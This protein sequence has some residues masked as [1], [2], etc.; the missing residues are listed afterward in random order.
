[1]KAEKL[2]DRLFSEIA[3]GRVG[4]SQ[5]YGNAF[6]GSSQYGSAYHYNSIYQ[7]RYVKKLQKKGYQVV[8]MK[9]YRPRNPQTAKQNA[10][11][12][13]IANAV[14]FDKFLINQHFF[15]R[16]N[17]PIS[18]TRSRSNVMRSLFLKEKPFYFGVSQFGDCEFGKQF[19]L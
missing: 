18:R 15:D 17:W 1:M 11:R 12:Q 3:R 9:F 10:N 16:Q 7:I 5:F 19:V 13:K 4:Y 2:Q 14:L 6:F 8:K